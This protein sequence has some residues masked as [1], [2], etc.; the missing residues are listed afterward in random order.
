ML[1]ETNHGASDIEPGWRQ[2]FAGDT[3]FLVRA[4]GEVTKAYV[5]FTNGPG[6]RLMTAFEAG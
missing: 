4:G 3:N 1:F 6:N 5:L 2:D